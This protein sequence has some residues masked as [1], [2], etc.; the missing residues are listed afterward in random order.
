MHRSARTLKKPA[1]AVV[2]A[3]TGVVVIFLTVLAY[4]A[5]TLQRDL[6]SA[7]A[8]LNAHV[9]SSTH[10]GQVPAAAGT[11]AP[12]A[13]HDLPLLFIYRRSYKTGSTSMSA[14]LSQL[15]VPLG[16]EEL[17]YSKRLVVTALRHRV[18]TP[19]GA[20]QRLK[21]MHHNFV[22]RDMHPAP[23]AVVIAD[24]FRDGYQQMTGYCRYF[25]KST[26]CHASESSR[27]SVARCLASADARKIIQYRWGGRDSEDADTY[28]D[29]P[30][31]VSHP[32]LSTVILR[33]VFPNLTLPVPD[34]LNVNGTTCEHVPALRAVYNR[35]YKE[36]DE[37]VRALRVRMLVLTGYHSVRGA[38]AANVS[39]EDLLDLAEKAERQKYDRGYD[40]SSPGWTSE[41]KSW[42]I[43]KKW[44]D[45]EQKKYRVVT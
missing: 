45:L 6:A 25:H 4:Q 16:Y 30:L 24:T 31:S 14:I 33:S 28:V 23:R 7:L 29:L 27:G 39:L 26:D 11:P 44:L 19:A 22:T 42:D 15:L 12:A 1:A 9:S 38:R 32:A 41:G 43:Y 35:Y 3:V 40:T 17:S 18:L 36:L 5:Y 13:E 10:A 21:T 2:T 8:A 34:R 20:R 37:Q